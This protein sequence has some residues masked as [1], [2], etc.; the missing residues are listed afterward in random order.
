MGQGKSM[1][2]KIHA[3]SVRGFPSGCPASIHSFAI[4]S[5]AVI[6]TALVRL[7]GISVLDEGIEAQMCSRSY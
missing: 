5:Q 7:V 4:L 2:L 6:S 3:V 1:K